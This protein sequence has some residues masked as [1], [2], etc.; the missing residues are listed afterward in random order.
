[1]TS[2]KKL[3]IFLLVLGTI[4]LV[5]V[6][7]ACKKETAP[8]VKQQEVQKPQNMYEGTVKMAVGKY[9]YLPTA[10]GMDM[11]AEGFNASSVLG[12]EVRVNGEVLPDK[13][14]I[15]RADAIEVKQGG[16]YSKVFTRSAE[17]NISEI[18]DMNSRTAYQGLLITGV[19]DASEWEG[20]GKAKAYGQLQ[21]SMIILTAESGA[22]IG[23]IVVDNMNDFAKFY[24]T[25]LHLFEKA[26]FYFN[27]KNSV[28]AAARTK[29]K[30]LF[31]ADVVYVA[32][33]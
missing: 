29:T 27:V 11:I 6:S 19:K 23:K 12:K 20:K 13:P 16:S 31:H 30:E 7:T 33:Y 3:G 4:S 26:W 25:K 15:F 10:K 32:L 21:G 18:M 9:L 1:M 5:F 22:E 8:A 2:A 14:W 28:D 17:P 24:M